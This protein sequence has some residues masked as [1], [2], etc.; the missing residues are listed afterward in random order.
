M[1]RFLASGLL[2]VLSTAALASPMVEVKKVT[3]GEG[4]EQPTTKLPKAPAMCTL[5]NS[6]TRI[7]C[8]DGK[9][10]D[11]DEMP[12]PAVSRSICNLT[13]VP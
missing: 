9:V 6:K 12:N 3:F 7:W 8:P 5:T 11:R 1:L 13:Q 4:C 10:F 2:L